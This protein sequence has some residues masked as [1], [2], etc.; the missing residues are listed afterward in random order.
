MDMSDS[1]MRIALEWAK[2]DSH[3]ILPNAPDRERSTMRSA[4]F[5]G[6]A[7]VLSIFQELQDSDKT[8]E[9]VVDLFKSL[10]QEIYKFTLALSEDK[11]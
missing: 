6:A 3:V 5:A 8:S 11:A 9:A 1:N 7:A 4:Y 2:F 10:N